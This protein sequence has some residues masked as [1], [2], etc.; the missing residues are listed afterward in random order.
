MEISLIHVNV[1]EKNLVT[2]LHKIKSLKLALYQR[3]IS[4]C[5]KFCIYLPL[6]SIVIYVHKEL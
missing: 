3:R 5:S 1:S 2:E 6:I 4:C